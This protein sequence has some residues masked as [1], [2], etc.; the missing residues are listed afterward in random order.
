M[1]KDVKKWAKKWLKTGHPW[2]GHKVYLTDTN[3]NYQH[4][5]GERKPSRCFVCGKEGGVF[6]TMHINNKLITLCTK[7]EYNENTSK[8]T[9]SKKQDNSQENKKI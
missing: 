4:I 3:S 5:F 9:I 8:K 7:C 2:D 6:K 1:K